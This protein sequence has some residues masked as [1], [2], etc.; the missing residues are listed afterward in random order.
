MTNLLIL[1]SI[2]ISFPN[3]IR[4]YNGS[5]TEAGKGEKK[6]G[7]NAFYKNDYSQDIAIDQ[8]HME[9]QFPEL[10]VLK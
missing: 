8:N 9:D 4:G 6:E 1:F 2:I 7:D 5:K 3:P 10:T